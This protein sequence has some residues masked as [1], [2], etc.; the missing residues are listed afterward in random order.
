MGTVMGNPCVLTYEFYSYID[1]GGGY[2][3]EVIIIWNG[4]QEDFVPGL[5]SNEFV[6]LC[7]VNNLGLQFTFEINRIELFSLMYLSSKI[8]FTLHHLSLATLKDSTCK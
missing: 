4:G 8:V 5:H 3:D 2:I 1:L 7:N 6:E